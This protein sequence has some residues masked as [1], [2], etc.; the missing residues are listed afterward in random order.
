MDAIKNIIGKIQNLKDTGDAQTL[1]QELENRQDFEPVSKVLYVRDAQEEGE[2]DYRSV[3]FTIKPETLAHFS[4][5]PQES[6]ITDEALQYRV[7]VE[8]NPEMLGLKVAVRREV[9]F[10]PL[11]LDPPDRFE[12]DV[13]V[14]HPIS[15]DMSFTEAFIC[16]NDTTKGFVNEC[17]IKF[18]ELGQKDLFDSEE[19]VTVRFRI[20]KLKHGP[21]IIRA[22]NELQS[23]NRQLEESLDS[24][25]SLTAEKDALE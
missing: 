12:G 1:F 5:W 14:L 16:E 7:R 19:S 15:P 24:F 20:R 9:L 17:L 10:Q 23:M 4:F 13:T 18:E 8:Q 3:D 25:N 6:Y 2:A 22:E 21:T 11:N